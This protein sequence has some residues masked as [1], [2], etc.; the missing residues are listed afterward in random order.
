MIHNTKNI[1]I[2][3]DGTPVVFDLIK[4]EKMPDVTGLGDVKIA[5]LRTPPK[6][7]RGGRQPYDWV[8]KIETIDGGLIESKDEMMFLAPESGYAPQ[9]EIKMD[10]TALDWSPNRQI[11]VYLRS[12]GGKVF[13]RVSFEFR[14]DSDRETTGFTFDAYINPAGSRILEF[15]SA[16]Q[17]D[18]AS[19]Q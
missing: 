19:L 15:D 17:I 3:Y 6:V 1:R 14:T 13:G 16:K 9:L 18:P 4:G 8:A 10:R 7:E 11:S 5:L 12:R 2:P